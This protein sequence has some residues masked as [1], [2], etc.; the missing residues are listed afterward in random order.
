[1][2]KNWIITGTSRGFG[3]IFAEAAL[4]RRDR[5]AAT[6]RDT[7]SITDLV[8]R[9]GDN[10]LPLALDVTDR[11]AAF[12]AVQA[13]HERF[14]RLDVVVNNAGYGLF[15]AV[16]EISEDEARRQIETNLLGALWVTQAALP[17]LREQ[18]FGHL[19]QVSSEGGV[20]AYPGFGLYHASKWGLEGFTESLA[21]EVGP[22][23]IGVTMVEPG[24]YRTDFAGGSL[25]RAGAIPAYDHVRSEIE[26]AFGA[27]GVVGD[28]EATGPAILE[29]VD[30]DEP[31]RRVFF[32]ATPL[33]RVRDDYESRLAT[34]EQWDELS[35]RAH[36]GGSSG[37]GS[38]L[39]TTR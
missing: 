31:P 28:P 15:G 33:R 21:R 22:L 3:R 24:P 17:I 35:Q 29:V 4:E 13:A 7:G 36:G 5:V 26:Q 30:A 18:G 38:R 37:P 9:F 8:E 11:S 1:M 20:Y 14:G 27:P 23:G 16:E 2:P 32:G 12:A 25:A 10:V 19:I 34:W 39:G 6:A